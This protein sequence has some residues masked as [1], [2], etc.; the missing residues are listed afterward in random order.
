MRRRSR[1]YIYIYIYL[2][3]LLNCIGVLG[4]LGDLDRCPQALASEISSSQN[5]NVS[6][7]VSQKL[8]FNPAPSNTLKYLQIPS[9]TF[10][11]T[12][13]YLQ[14][15]SNAFTCHKPLIRSTCNKYYLGA[16]IR[17]DAHNYSEADRKIIA[18]VHT[19]CV[20]THRRSLVYIYIY[21]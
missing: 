18:L 6:W 5:C 19:L 11:Y 17:C 21:R 4:D 10:T 15:H 8:T 7:E 3:Y 16:Q 20:S 12:L 1:I 14:I 13:K 2:S 9:K